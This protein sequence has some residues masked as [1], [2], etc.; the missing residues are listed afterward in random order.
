MRRLDQGKTPRHF[1][2][3]FIILRIF[4]MY[5]KILRRIPQPN[6]FIRPR[7]PE[8]GRIRVNRYLFSMKLNDAY[9]FMTNDFYLYGIRFA[10]YL[11]MLWALQVIFYKATVKACTLHYIGQYIWLNDNSNCWIPIWY[12][13]WSKCLEELPLQVSCLLLLRY[14][15]FL[16]AWNEI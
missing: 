8:V 10:T 15:F 6:Q 12:K 13:T 5:N 1:S 11:M 16:I 7:R 14:Y 3:I 2:V 9:I 4:R